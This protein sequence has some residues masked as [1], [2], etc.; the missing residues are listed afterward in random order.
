[1]KIRITAATLLASIFM[2]VNVMAEDII[3][4]KRPNS[5]F[6]IECNVEVPSGKTTVYISGVVLSIV[7]KK[8]EEVS[9][10]ACDNT[11]TKAKNGTK[12]DRQDPC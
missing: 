8:A 1:M 12:V 11:K 10:A 7:N 4:H 5:D 6:K 3:R 2:L 9:I